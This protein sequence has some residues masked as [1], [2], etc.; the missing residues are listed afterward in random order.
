MM[1][2]PTVEERLEWTIADNA[3]KAIEITDLRDSA[4]TGVRCM[5]KRNEAMAEVDRLTKLVD[6]IT[7]TAK[8]R[9]KKM[10]K[11]RD[12]L[13]TIS[14]WTQELQ[15]EAEK[16]GPEACIMMWRGC[17]AVA[18]TTLKDDK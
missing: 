16:L 13:R 8:K 4:K 3:K 14:T 1:S 5:E 11:Y 6:D 15:D 2:N 7:Y 9:K 10:H 18:I 12:A 17:A